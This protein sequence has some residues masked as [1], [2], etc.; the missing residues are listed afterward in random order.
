MNTKA[1]KVPSVNLSDSKDTG[2]EWLQQ[3]VKEIYQIIFQKT[4]IESFNKK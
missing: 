4:G 3:G 1:G 2:K